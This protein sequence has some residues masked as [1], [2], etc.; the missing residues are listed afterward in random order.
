[1]PDITPVLNRSKVHK[2][3]TIVFAIA[4]ETTAMPAAFFGVDYKPIALPSGFKDLGFITTDGVTAADSISVEPTTMLQ[5]L[6]PVRTDLTGREMSLSVVF[7]ESNA[8]VQGLFH[9]LPVADWPADRDSAWDYSDEGATDFPYYRVLLFMQ[10]GVGDKAL[11]RVEGGW[12]AKV[13]SK[14]D[15]ALGRGNP[16]TYGVTFK[17]FRDEVD[18]ITY[19]RAEDGPS[20]HSPSTLPVIAA[21]TPTGGAVGDVLK[22]TGSRFTGVTGITIDAVTV[23]DYQVHDAG[24]IYLAIPSGVS[25]AADLVVTTTAGASTA[26]AYTAAVV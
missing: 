18:D 2:W 21:V 17:L 25:G 4:D 24:T 20:L 11:Y 23:T 5:D 16:E 1:M 22:V 19:R 12:K 15:R 26:F 13:T 6:E 10:D 7:G 14:T 3:G 9:G 8:W